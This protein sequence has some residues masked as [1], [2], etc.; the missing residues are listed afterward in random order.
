M[1]RIHLAWA[2]LVLSVAACAD[3]TAPM[4][5]EQL[6]AANTEVRG[7]A[8]A[9]ERVHALEIELEI[10][11]PGFTVSGLYRATREGYMR[12]DIFAEGERVYTEGVGPNGA[13]QMVRGATAGSPESEAGEAKLKR[14]IVGNLYG[15]HELAGLGYRLT[16][17]SP[18]TIDG[19]AYQVIEQTAPDGVSETLFLDEVSKLKT[20]ERDMSALHPDLDPTKKHFETL[21]LDYQPTDGVQFSRKSEKR[22]LASGE[23]VQ[24]TL[25][26]SV[27]VNPKLDMAIFRRPLSQ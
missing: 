27:K 16:L 24:T 20:R 10:T 23:L 7:G 26:K 6:V 25:L 14:G 22:D 21:W 11:E 8:A 4:S 3:Q 17:E 13:W 18:Q 1:N 2:F 19:K 5:L 9:V 12:V 15:L